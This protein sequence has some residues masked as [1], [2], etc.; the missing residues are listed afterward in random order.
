[1]NGKY[2]MYKKIF[3]I[4][5]FMSSLLNAEQ[6]NSTLTI[7]QILAMPED[8]IDLG[9]ACLV[10]AKDAY[11]NL[12][13]GTFNYALDFM[14]ERIK[15]LNKGETDPNRRIALLNSYFFR[16]GWWND[17]IT[18]TY[19]TDDLEATKTQNQFL[20]GFIA[21]K[22]G[23]CATMS[24][25]YLVIADRLGWPIKP[26][27]SAKHIYCRYIQRGFKENNIEATCGGGYISDSQYVHQVGIPQKAVDNG[28]YLRTL[29]KKEYIASLLQ[30][31]VRYFQ[32]EKKDLDKAMHYCKLS[33]SLDSTFSSAYWNLG[34]LLR[35][36]AIQLD[37]IRYERIEDLKAEYY[38]QP[39][40]FPQLS[41]QNQYYSIP[42]RPQTMDEYIESLKP[43]PLTKPIFKINLLKVDHNIQR[44]NQQS[45]LSAEI[46]SID[47]QYGEH[48]QQL[49]FWSHQLKDKAKQLGIVRRFPEEFFIKQS[50]AIE[51]FKRTGKY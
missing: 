44:Q 20:N 48:I 24:M 45:M 47:S 18:F 11:P 30:N 39:R 35:E 23:S 27:R 33:L 14:V 15:Y 22:K 12:N 36:K 37:S 8:S 16:L 21:T 4:L 42:T 32:E 10:L 51:E 7:E 5:L 46:Q 26:V 28:V 49:L 6:K 17:S 31:N 2:L 34:E 1:M 38:N 9:T 43:K 13:I 25:L 29:T 41:P 50:Q 19:D 40:T 3:L